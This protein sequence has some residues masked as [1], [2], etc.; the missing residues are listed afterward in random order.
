MATVGWKGEEVSV[1][2]KGLQGVT[3]VRMDCKEYQRVTRG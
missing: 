2:Y 1:S 3:R